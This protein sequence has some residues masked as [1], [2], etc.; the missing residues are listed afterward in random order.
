M[1][2]IVVTAIEWD[3][4]PSK[5]QLPKDDAAAQLGPPGQALLPGLQRRRHLRLPRGLTRSGGEARRAAGSRGPRL[6]E[7]SSKAWASFGV[8]RVFLLFFFWGGGEGA[9]N[10]HQ[11]KNIVFFVLWGFSLLLFFLGGGG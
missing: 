1:L 7:L 9:S 3:L 6:L 2:L 11:E 10:G 4:G 8:A 5:F